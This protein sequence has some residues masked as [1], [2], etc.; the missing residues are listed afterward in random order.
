MK[1][2]VFGGLDWSNDGR[3][4]EAY[5]LVLSDKPQDVRMQ[6]YPLS[7]QNKKREIFYLFGDREFKYALIPRFFAKFFK[8]YDIISIAISELIARSRSLEYLIIDGAMRNSDKDTIGRLLHPIKLPKI[9][10]TKEADIYYQIV[11]IAHH[12]AYNLY[13]E[14]TSPG[15]IEDCK[16]YLKFLIQPQINSYSDLFCKD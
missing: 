8:H 15:S 5:T 2:G 11:N 12:V 7:K 16:K 1:K 13:K 10:A 14:H 6:D 9:I 3:D 4:P